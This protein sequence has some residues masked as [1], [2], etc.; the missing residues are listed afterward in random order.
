MKLNN[1]KMNDSKWKEYADKFD[2]F[3]V[4][5]EIK[6]EIKDT[7]PDT[8]ESSPDKEEDNDQY[9]NSSSDGESKK[10]K[11]NPKKKAKEEQKGNLFSKMRSF[12][13]LSKKEE[14][15]RRIM[16]TKSKK[17]PKNFAN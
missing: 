5:E 10:K 4:I 17:L 16:S 6:K 3:Q 11:P 1:K 13:G 14:R 15:E 8:P 12:V 7:F 2:K 9:S